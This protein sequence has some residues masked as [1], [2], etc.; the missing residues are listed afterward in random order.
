[1]NQTFGYMESTF[2]MDQLMVRYD[3]EKAHRILYSY[4]AL[5]QLE[6]NH[7][8]ILQLLNLFEDES[9]FNANNFNSF[10]LAVIVD[11]IQKT[12][13]YYLSKKLLEIE[14][15]IALLLKDYEAQHPLL[16]VLQNFYARYH[17]HLADHIH[18]EETILLPYIL[19]LEN[20]SK[21]VFESSSLMQAGFSLQHFI[22]SHHDVENDL[23]VAR[24]AILKYNPPATNSTPYRILLSQLQALEK[25]LAIHA[26]IEDHV[27]LPRALRLERELFQ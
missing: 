11:Y 22:E 25:D 2:A 16:T 10:S 8:F 17:K 13:N 23:S 15:S 21:N 12:H 18:E 9:S 27:L 20:K 1:L 19:A 7:A 26:L 5:K 4:D 6:V 14:Q 24:K 3:L